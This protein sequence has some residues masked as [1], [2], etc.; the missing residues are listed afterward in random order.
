MYKVLDWSNEP[1]HY[2]SKCYIK[3]A[4]MCLIGFL[5]HFQ[6]HDCALSSNNSM[7]LFHCN[8]YCKLDSAVRSTI[9]FTF[10][11]YKTCLCPGKCSCYLQYHANRISRTLAQPSPRLQYLGKWTNYCLL[12]NNPNLLSII[13][14]WHVY[15]IYFC[16]QQFQWGLLF[17]RQTKNDIFVA[18]RYCS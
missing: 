7:V 2:C 3:S 6:V 4:Q 17:W 10:Y 18:N 8:S 13:Q 16:F 12:L 1:L 11:P 5:I 14:I 9:I 15:T